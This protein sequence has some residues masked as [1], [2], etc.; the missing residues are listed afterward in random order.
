MNEVITEK[1]V[2]RDESGIY[3]VGVKLLTNHKRVYVFDGR[4]PA[5]W[6]NRTF[7]PLQTI[8]PAL[9]VEVRH[10]IEARKAA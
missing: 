1:R 3:I 8:S 4:A 9:C 6:A 7:Q 5:L 2:V 10:V